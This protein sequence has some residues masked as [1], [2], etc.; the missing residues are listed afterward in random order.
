[1]VKRILLYVGIAFVLV[2]AGLWVWSGGL[3]AV[4]RVAGTFASPFGDAYSF[5]LPWQIEIPEVPDTT[6]GQNGDYEYGNTDAD[7]ELASL[8]NEYTQLEAEVRQA[9]AAAP[10]SRYAGHVELHAGGER[11]S[12][13][14]SEYIEI[15]TSRDVGEFSL[16]GWSL[17]STKGNIRIDL[18]GAADPLRVGTVNTPKLLPV[19]ADERVIVTTGRSPVGVSFRENVCTGYLAQLQDFD[20][21]LSNAC[22][23]AT[24]RVPATAANVQTYGQSCMDFIARIPHCQF[25]T[26]VPSNLSSSC[27]LLVTNAF[28]YN[29][30]VDDMREKE[31]F[32]LRTTRLYLGREAE[33]WNNARDSI[34]LL[35]EEGLIVDSLTY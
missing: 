28:T 33:L 35:D 16:D 20:P 25:P 15:L 3:S 6:T 29:G 1:M 8:E 5:T 11:E 21:Q 26:S 30:C 19:G 9:Q 7:A 10:R 24:K 2:L 17:E 34:K 13:A 18:P 23:A 32:R 27:K 4:T 14:Q 31:G 12:D 22:P